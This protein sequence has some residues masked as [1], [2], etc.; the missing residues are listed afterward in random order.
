MKRK[1]LEDLGLSKE[2]ADAVMKINGSDIENAKEVA[3]AEVTNLKAENENLAKQVKDRDKQIEGL[4]T[5]AGDNR[6]L[7]KQIE[8]LQEDNKAQAD[9]HAKEIQKMKLDAAVEKALADAGAKNVNA[10]RGV[11]GD[12]LK[13]AKLS[14]DGTVKGLAE[15]IEKLKGDDGTKFLF[16]EHGQ[17]RQQFTGFQPGNPTTVPDSTQAGYETRLAEARKNGNQLEV[18]RIKQ[19]A[20][21]NDGIALM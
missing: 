14:D 21:Q 17:N 13:D 12:T 7:K 10:L 3:G 9:A 19:E 8:Q 4:K 16:N 11:L 1:E 18:I 6:E 15:Q 5:S 2:Q 20:F